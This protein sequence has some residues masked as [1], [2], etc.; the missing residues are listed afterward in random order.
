LLLELGTFHETEGGTYAD[1]EFYRRLREEG[2][3]G[4]VIPEMLAL[5]RYRPDSLMRGLSEATQR[6]T[7]MEMRD[8]R[9]RR[10]LLEGL[11]PA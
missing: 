4:A 8:R 6:P 1:W 2:R 7:I 3:F 5:Y 11:G 9:I 10:R